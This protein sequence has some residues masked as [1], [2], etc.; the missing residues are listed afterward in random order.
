MR[1]LFSYFD[2]RCLRADPSRVHDCCHV[3]TGTPVEETPEQARQEGDQRLKEQHKRNPLIVVD[4]RLNVLLGQPFAGNRL[5]HR[6][7]VRVAHPADGVGVFAV[8]RGELGWT[9]AGDRLTYEL[10]RRHQCT[11]ADEDDDKYFT[12]K[13]NN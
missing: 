1:D 7:V 10:L 13:Y 5:F 8:A 9:P 4:V 3:D 6:K 12:R 2:V 11:K